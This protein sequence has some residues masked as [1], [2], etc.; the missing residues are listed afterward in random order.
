MVTPFPFTR[1]VALPSSW[2]LVVVATSSCHREPIKKVK[3]VSLAEK[4]WMLNVNQKTREGINCR[5]SLRL[6]Q[7]GRF[8]QSIPDVQTSNPT[9]KKILYSFYAI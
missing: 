5:M 4:Q 7:P 3:I 1:F 9:L 8:F 6:A 2:Q